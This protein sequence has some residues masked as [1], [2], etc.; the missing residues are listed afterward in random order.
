[1]PFLALAVAVAAVSTSGPLIAYA[2]AP[3]LAIAFWRNALATGVLVP[4]VVVR[5]GWPHR[6]DL[7]LCGVSGLTLAVHFATWI[8]SARLTSVATATALGA[9]QPVWAGLI[10]LGLGRR[11]P[12]ATWFGIA[13]AVAGAAVATGADVAVAGRAVAGD[14]LALAG[15]MAA[16]AYVT[17]GERLR[18]RVSTLGY[19][20]IVYG[21][22]A[23][24]LAAVCLVAGVPLAGYSHRDWLLI[25]AATVGPQF[26][27]HS[28][29]NYALHRVSATVVSIVLL[30]EVP[31]AA[32][33][34][35]WFLD[36]LPRRAA[37]PGLALL[38]L[39][40]AVAAYSSGR[41]RPTS[42]PLPGPEP[43][44]V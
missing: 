41:T 4:A 5:G 32:L 33:I 29:V 19:T 16:A 27:G 39:G 21:I 34:G 1:M 28:L 17:V 25:V 7:A 12:R 13:L 43:P 10:G 37:V 18:P 22:C 38:L 42:P 40:V 14:A 15:G 44:P 26:L 2:A 6:R 20:A 3:T 11:L 30:L 24:L 35:W 8:P 36:Q 9:I 23:V 31:G